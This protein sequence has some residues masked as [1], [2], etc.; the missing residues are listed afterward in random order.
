MHRDP[1]IASQHGFTL[2]E[3]MVAMVAGM[4]LITLAFVITAQSVATSQSQR[5]VSDV[6][7]SLHAAA[8]LVLAD[9]RSAG[10]EMGTLQLSGT[11]YRP[12]SVQDGVDAV[13][14]D[15]GTPADELEILYSDDGLNAT[16]TG[17]SF[18]ASDDSVSVMPPASINDFDSLVGSI[19]VI[20][21][22][23]CNGVSASCLIEITKVQDNA[24]HIQHKPGG[25]VNQPGNANCAALQNC[26]TGASFLSFNAHSYR[27]GPPAYYPQGM[28]QE[29]PSGGFIAN[30]W[31]NLAPGF[32]DLQV[33][34]CIDSNNNGL[35]DST[36]WVNSGANLTN[37]PT[38]TPPTGGI[39]AVRVTLVARTFASASGWTQG[40]QPTAE[41]HTPPTMAGTTNATYLYRAFVETAELRN[42][43]L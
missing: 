5:D 10:Y 28:L 11:T 27:I 42:G 33:A 15:T 30:D 17:P 16:I 3:L 23:S 38:A 37:P 22:P 1:R 29:S 25:T 12:I 2:V 6:E 41:N 13:A 40:Q 39:M 18:N 8:N 34:L 14:T 19:A 21:N 31:V 35:C 9:V 43:P 7:Q 24:G 32:V 4:I 26:W 20:Y 36:E